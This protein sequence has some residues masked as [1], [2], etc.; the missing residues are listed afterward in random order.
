MGSAQTK[1][2]NPSKSDG[3][4]G[5]QDDVVIAVM[6]STGTGKSS[7][8]RLVSGDASVQ[9]GDSL[10]SETDEVQ[11]V[12]FVDP[13]SGRKVTIVD[14]PGFDDSRVGI[15]NTSVLKMIAEFLVQE[16]DANRKLNGLVYLHRITDNRFGGQ[17]RGN[18]RMFRELCGTE[19]YP[20]VVI[21]TTFW[22]KVNE[23]DGANREKQLK[24]N[25]CKELVDGGAN[26]MRSDRTMEAARTVLEHI[27]TLNPTNVR[28]QEEIRV[29][30]KSFEETAAGSVRQEQLNA[31]LEAHR[32]E[33]A[34]IREEMKRSAEAEKKML[35]EELAELR[36]H[37]A[38]TE[39]EFSQ[40]RQGIMQ[41][42]PLVLLL[43]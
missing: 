24:S 18:L 1:D 12:R 34:E 42:I 40:L 3:T 17:A 25:Y 33:L 26:L 13:T 32:K 2:D 11:V 21:L 31:I 6:G 7:F 22:D 27:F 4:S 29:D 14:T 41:L 16:Y 38:Q 39:K 37:V 8:I 23:Q 28:I 15:T 20:N 35:Q 10:E 19:K 5:D 43:L 30:G 9:V 36:K